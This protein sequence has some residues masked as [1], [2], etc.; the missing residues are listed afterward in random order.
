[1]G[2]GTLSSVASPGSSDARRAEEAMRNDQQTAEAQEENLLRTLCQFVNVCLVKIDLLCMRTQSAFSVAE[3][4]LSNLCLPEL[5]EICF[6]A[7]YTAARLVGL[8]DSYRFASAGLLC[9]ETS[10]KVTVKSL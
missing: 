10:H 7:V 9:V 3:E 5:L 6:V 4:V 2:G 1:M 8:D